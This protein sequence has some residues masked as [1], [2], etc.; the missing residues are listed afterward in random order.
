MISKLALV[1]CLFWA[2]PDGC[3]HT[4]VTCPAPRS[5][6][7]PLQETWK[8]HRPSQ[9]QLQF[10][11]KLG[12]LPRI[13]WNG[14]WVDCP[15]WTNTP[16]FLGRMLFPESRLQLITKARCWRSRTAGMGE[17]PGGKR[18]PI[19]D[20]SLSLTRKG[21]KILS[22]RGGLSSSLLQPSCFWGWIPE[23][24]GTCPLIWVFSN[25]MNRAGEA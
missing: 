25:E 23:T 24:S 19:P 10:K 6:P 18:R 1:K 21:K 8:I 7:T 9:A 20:A 22:C 16:T 17:A 2:G 13:T 14:L 5:P 4:Q 3:G 12:K 11:K 15:N